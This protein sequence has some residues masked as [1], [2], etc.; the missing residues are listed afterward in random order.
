MLA[1][2][3]DMYG[4]QNSEDRVFFSDLDEAV[5]FVLDKNGVQGLAAVL[6]N[7]S[8]WISD[9]TIESVAELREEWLLQS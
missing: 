2:I 8:D 4:P 6:T 1:Q 3:Q 7:L 5:L 9:G